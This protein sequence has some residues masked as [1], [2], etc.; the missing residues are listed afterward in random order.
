MQLPFGEDSFPLCVSLVSQK[1]FLSIQSGNTK[2]FHPFVLDNLDK[3][4]KNNRFGESNRNVRFF[5]QLVVLMIEFGDEDDSSVLSSLF[6]NMCTLE[7]SATSSMTDTLWLLNLFDLLLSKKPADYKTAILKEFGELRSDWTRNGRNF[8]E[9]CG[10]L[11]L[12]PI[13]SIFSAGLNPTVFESLLY[14]SY[15]CI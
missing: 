10:H 14:L 15:I 13:T 6:L 4:W 9:I 5:L 1:V 11:P 3:F 2:W 12:Q 7:F 8:S